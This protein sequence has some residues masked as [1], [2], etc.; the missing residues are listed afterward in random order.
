MKFQINKTIFLFLT[1]LSVSFS[2]FVGVQNDLMCDKCF[3]EWND[4]HQNFC[5]CLTL[6]INCDVQMN[7]FCQNKQGL[8][9]KCLSNQCDF[10]DMLK[11][12]P[13]N[14]LKI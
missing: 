3:S 10:C 5:D 8:L 9:E 7:C 1:L 14:N 11:P 2:I 6:L 4:C 13:Y 12:N